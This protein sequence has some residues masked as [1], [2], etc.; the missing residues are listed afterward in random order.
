MKNNNDVFPAGFDPCYA[1]YAL[2]GLADFTYEFHS[3]GPGVNRTLT[4]GQ[5]VAILGVS[6]LSQRVANELNDYLAALGEAGIS[7]PASD[8]ELKGSQGNEV[9]DV[10]G[11][12][13]VA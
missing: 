5:H 12:Y 13:V 11:L 10:R 4:S 7:L 8:E 2:K 6:W 1:I 9:R 3:E